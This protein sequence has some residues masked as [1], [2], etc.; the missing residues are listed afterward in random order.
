MLKSEVP[1]TVHGE[2]SHQGPAKLRVSLSHIMRDTMGTPVNL[3]LR[4]GHGGGDKVI[5]PKSSHC[6]DNIS[7]L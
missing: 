7:C 5:T 6:T 4:R 2:P 3:C 1:L